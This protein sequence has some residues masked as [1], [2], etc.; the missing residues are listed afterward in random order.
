MYRKKGF[1]LIELL[2]VIAIIGILAAILLP[3]L[4]RAR[5]AAR[6][7]SCANNLKQWGLIFKMYT[8][9]WDGRFPPLI[10][11][12]V[13]PDGTIFVIN[14]RWTSKAFTPDIYALYPEYWNDLNLY[15]CPSDPRTRQEKML[16]NDPNDSWVYNDEV[17]INNFDGGSY[18]Y[19]GYA[20]YGEPMGCCAVIVLDVIAEIPSSTPDPDGLRVSGFDVD[21]PCGSG[22]MC[23]TLNNI[24]NPNLPGYS[25]GWA[26]PTTIYR[27]REGIERFF[28]TDIN[29]PAA[30]A[31][32]QSELPVLWDKVVGHLQ[33]GG[34]GKFNHIPGGGNVLY[35]D[36]HVEFIRY[37]GEWPYAKMWVL[38]R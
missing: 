9:E 32:A 4:A 3:A 1:T 22:T 27:L 33:W 29:N 8:N 7:A 19:I 36:G 10:H 18:E 31:V 2:V 15:I 16:S 13:A 35:A 21:I 11:N 14:D 25:C 5:E 38:T 34:G 12:P 6:R 37:P 23:N 30:T 28:I 17:I 20:A 24:D 26:N